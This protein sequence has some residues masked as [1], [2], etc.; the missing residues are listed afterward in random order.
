MEVKGIKGPNKISGYYTNS[1]RFDIRYCKDVDK[2]DQVPGLVEFLSY[3]YEQLLDT[4]RR[5]ILDDDLSESGMQPIPVFLSN[6]RP[7][8]KRYRMDDDWVAK[9]I[10]KELQKNYSED[11]KEL[12]IKTILKKRSFQPLIPGKYCNNNHSLEGD[13]EDFGQKGPHIVLYYRNTYRLDEGHYKAELSADLAHEYFHY[14]HDSYTG[15]TF[16]KTGRQRNL[17]VESLADFFAFAYS[18]N[19]AE[20]KVTSA[21]FKG[22]AKD[23]FDTWKYRFGSSW[24]YAYAYCFFY[25]KSLSPMGYSDS[26]DDIRKNG[27]IEKFNMVL[28]Y[29]KISMNRAYK[30]LTWNVPFV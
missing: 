3:E 2:K 23:R 26:L 11:E 29:S 12:V 5:F 19:K 8:D 13:P 10:V 6:E 24:P 17:V 9:E 1:K 25:G 7:L 20:V 4:R 27:C 22:N 14:L 21:A 18:L 15:E 30:E 28:K 16:N